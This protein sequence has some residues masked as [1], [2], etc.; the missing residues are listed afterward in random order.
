MDENVSQNDGGLWM[1]LLCVEKAS[2]NECQM[3]RV[4]NDGTRDEEMTVEKRQQPKQ[5]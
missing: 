2:V 4:V 5:E 3:F 1:K